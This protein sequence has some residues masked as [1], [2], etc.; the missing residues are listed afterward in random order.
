M[1]TKVS[2][3]CITGIAHNVRLTETAFMQGRRIL[4][5]AVV[6]RETIQVFHRNKMDGFYLK[7]ILR[8]L[9]K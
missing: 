6:L 3:N 8:R 4:E 7:S 9:M 5:G 1:F 2:A